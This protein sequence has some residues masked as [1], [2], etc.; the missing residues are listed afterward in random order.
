MTPPIVIEET[1]PLDPDRRPQASGWLEDGLHIRI[2]E[3]L[4]TFP[5]SWAGMRIGRPR[6]GESSERL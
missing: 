2:A 5:T 4:A 1:G 3:A 6:T